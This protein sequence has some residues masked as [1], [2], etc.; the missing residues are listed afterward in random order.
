M[1]II[2]WNVNGIR[3]NIV[4]ANSAKYK[5]RREIVAGS[6]LQK[7]IDEHNPDIIC[8]QETRLGEDL[9][10]LF[11]SENIKQHFPYQYWSSSKGE[12]GRSQ[13]RYSGTSIWSKTEPDSVLYDA[14]GLLDREGRFIQV[15]FGNLIVIT[16][17][18]PNTGSNWDY[19]LKHWEPII[20]AYL[21]TLSAGDTPVVYCGDNN[22]AN[23]NDVWFGDLLDKKYEMEDD[24][25]IKEYLRKQ[26]MSKKNLHSGETTLCGYS[27]EEREAFQLLTSECDLV[28]CFRTKHP[29]IIDQFSYFNIRV[30]PSFENNMGWLIDR[31]LIQKKFSKS[32]MD[33]KILHETGIRTKEGVFISD[34]LPILL[35]LDV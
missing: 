11:E 23:R 19:R 25:K 2:S 22:I 9:Y 13:N 26:I 34:H 15:N 12:K 18:T 29:G 24:A 10:S 4:D 6:P 30:R 8:F 16:T 17:Y 27:V 20:R 21:H 5:K 35:E 33:C 32:I 14:P 1:K 3:S 31:F 28:D 7:I